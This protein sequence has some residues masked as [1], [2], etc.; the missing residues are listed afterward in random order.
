MSTSK[1]KN[2]DLVRDSLE[3]TRQMMPESGEPIEAGKAYQSVAHSAAIAVQDAAN[4]LRNMSTLSSTA[5]G[6]AMAQ[7]IAHPDKEQYK[8]I[9]ETAQQMIAQATHQF[10]EIGKAAITV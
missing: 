7:W 6:V 3:K 10:E 5:I 9:I 4:M 1:S 2:I 8:E